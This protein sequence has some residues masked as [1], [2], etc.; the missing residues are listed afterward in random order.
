MNQKI[1]IT[2]L[3]SDLIGLTATGEYELVYYAKL[4]P[5][6]HSIT[7]LPKTK[8]FM[9]EGTMIFLIYLIHFI[10]IFVVVKK[11]L[12]AIDRRNG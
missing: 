8:P 1:V 10:V 11:I 5:F 7:V 12:N 2:E 4:E 9:S 3:G 6:V